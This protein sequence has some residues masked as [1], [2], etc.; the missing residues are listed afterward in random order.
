MNKLLQEKLLEI[1]QLI[2]QYSEQWEKKDKF[3]ENLLFG[4]QIEPEE[5][6]IH[7]REGF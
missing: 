3:I 7:S 2:K 5:D 4:R 1:E 6:K